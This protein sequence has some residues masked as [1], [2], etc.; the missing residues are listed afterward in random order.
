MSKVLFFDT[1]TLDIKPTSVILSAGLVC[2]DSGEDYTFDDLVDLGV[3]LKFDVRT[4]KAAGRTISK[5]TVAWWRK[6]GP[7]A[8]KVILPSDMD[9]RYDDMCYAI[10]SYVNEAG[11]NRKNGLAYCRGPDFDFSL[12]KDLYWQQEKDIFAF[13]N[14]VRDVRTVLAVML[15][16]KLKLFEKSFEVPKNFVPHNSLHDCCV[17][18]LKI[19]KAIQYFETGE[20]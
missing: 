13:F 5:D 14:C 18:V 15:G 3:N 12:M 11:F 10:D 17:D 6:Q 20:M 16:N 8:Q 19:Q 7:N 9:I 1:E 2:F 4:Q